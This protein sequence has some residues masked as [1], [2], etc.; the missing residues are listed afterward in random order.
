MR[1]FEVL[2]ACDLGVFPSW[3]EPWGY[4]PEESIAHSVPTVT[5]DLAGFGLWARSQNKEHNELGVE[6]LQRRQQG[7]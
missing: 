4:T 2:S 6:V 7:L 1:Y 3:Y 5:S